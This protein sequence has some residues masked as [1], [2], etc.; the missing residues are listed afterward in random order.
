MKFIPAFIGLA[1]GLAVGSGAAAVL[2][3]HWFVAAMV[4]FGALVALTRLI[5]YH[6]KA[7]AERRMAP[8]YEKAKRK[9]RIRKSLERPARR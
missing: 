4:G 5:E 8:A 7:T 9:R 6:L 1:A 2:G 3:L